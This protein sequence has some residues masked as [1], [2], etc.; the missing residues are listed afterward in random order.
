MDE[1]PPN[2]RKARAVDEPKIERVTSAEVRR[3]GGLGQKFKQVFFGG[4]AR[5]A[6]QY[7]A[8]AVIVPAMKDMIADAGREAV[9]R[10]VYGE[11]RRRGGYSGGGSSSYGSIAGNVNYAGM[12]TKPKQDQPRSVPRTAM[13]RN[14]FGEILIPSLQEANDVIDQMFEII[15]R[16]GRVSVAELYAMTD[17]RATHTDEKWGW[18]QLKGSRPERHRSGAWVLGLPRPEPLV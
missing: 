14:D 8:L 4:D 11:S 6:A 17:I 15:S 12:N 3:K 18:T 1:F 9:D 13:A 5:G 7:V 2:S 10:M 16:Y